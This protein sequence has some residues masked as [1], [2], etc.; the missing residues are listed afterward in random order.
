MSEKP[1]IITIRQ[2][3]NQLGISPQT[4]RRFCNHG[5]LY[6]VRR[7]RAGYRIFTPAQVDEIDLAVNLHACGMSLTEIK[8]YLRLARSGVSTASSRKL[9][10]QTKKRQLWQ[11]LSALQKNIDFIERQEE[12]IDESQK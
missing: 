9:L 1:E 8:K 11:E 5:L 3:A 6:H 4:I 2:A 12:L 7:T 10:L